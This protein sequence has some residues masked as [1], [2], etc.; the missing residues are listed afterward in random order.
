MWERRLESSDRVRVIAASHGGRAVYF[1]VAEGNAAARVPPRSVLSTGRPDRV[2]TLLT[3]AV[4]SI[5]LAAA[6]VARRNLRA[7]AGDPVAARKLAIAIGITAV[8][9]VAL[10]THHVPIAEVEVSWL[11]GVTGWGLLWA[12]FSWMAYV[13]LEPYLRRRLPGTLISWTRLISGRLRD[14]LVGRDVLIGLVAAV[15]LT[16]LLIART[17]TI[18]IR[19]A[20]VL[21]EPVLLSL[22]SARAAM[23]VIAYVVQDGLLY[24]IGLLF[25]LVMIRQVTRKTWIA[26]MVLMLA[27]SAL[28]PGAVSGVADLPFVVLFGLT[29]LLT[30]LRFGLLTAIVMQICERLLTRAPLTLH[31]DSWYF[32]LSLAILMLVSACAIYGFIVSLAGRPA[33]GAHVAVALDGS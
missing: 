7:G 32:G 4:I 14:P 8:A 27:G 6:V 18:G 23:A 19:A 24:G 30:T 5:F 21:I 15:G 26:V 13:S 9:A 2:E 33:F 12:A 3:T 10:R 22:Q 17:H 1:E 29:V 16:A 20:D 11:F 31:T 25:S 28:T